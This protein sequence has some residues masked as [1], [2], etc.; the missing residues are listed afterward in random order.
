MNTVK[1]QI[2][3]ALEWIEGLGLPEFTQATGVM[4][5]RESGFCCLGLGSFLCG[6]TWEEGTDLPPDDE[7]FAFEVGLSTTSGEYS[8][9]RDDDLFDEVSEWLNSNYNVGSILSLYELNDGTDMG[10]KGIQAILKKFPE[11]YFEPKVAKG[12]H[13][14][15]DYL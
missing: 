6:R 3:M 9:D 1:S 13:A 2:E 8:E 15:Y 11:F 14:V 10:F 12:I 5:D 7:F 4:G